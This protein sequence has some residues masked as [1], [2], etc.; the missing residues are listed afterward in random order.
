MGSSAGHD[1]HTMSKRS[2]ARTRPCPSSNRRSRLSS[3]VTWRRSCASFVQNPALIRA[4]SPREHQA[5]L[6]QY[7]AANGVEGFRQKTPKS[8]VEVAKLLLEAGA[9]VDAPNWPDGPAGPGT[10]LG[11]VAT[12]V[13]PARVGVQIPL[14]QTLLDY[15]ANI[16]GIPE[17][18][19]PLIAALHNGR[20][21][22]AEFLAAHGA[23]LNLEGAAG[24]GRLDVVKRFLNDDGNLKNATKT[25][26]E[27]GFGWACRKKSRCEASSGRIYDVTPSRSDSSS[28]VSL[29]VQQAGT[30]QARSRAD[31]SE[32]APRAPAAAGTS[33]RLLANVLTACGNRGATVH[34]PGASER[35]CSETFA[36]HIPRACIM[37]GLPLFRWSF[38]RPNLATTLLHSAR[39]IGPR[40]DSEPGAPGQ[41]CARECALIALPQN[42][43]VRLPR[44]TTKVG[45]GHRDGLRSAAR[46]QEILRKS[47]SRDGEL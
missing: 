28:Y 35:P 34:I 21:E 38:T 11:E 25:E 40:K 26:M 46:S 15:G 8:A 13:H 43:A 7:V 2:L 19:N 37:T 17:G 18:W 23:R 30:Q 27:S 45:K 6:L 36:G 4:R 5:T 10:T 1:L 12:S 3:P 39:C 9:E 20:P 33:T 41:T 32:A 31:A 29:P 47:T 44:I 42:A 22:A 24:V 14:M 16:N